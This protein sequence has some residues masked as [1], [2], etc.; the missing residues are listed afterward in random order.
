MTYTL[1][2]SEVSYFTG[3]A[4]AFLDWKRID[5]SEAPAT[6]D[7]YRD[8]IMPRVGWPVIPVVLGPGEEVLQDTSDII[9]ILDARHGPPSVFPDGPVQKLAALL[10]E[11]YGDE[12]LVLPAMH[13]RWSYNRDFAYSEFGKLSA[14]EAPAE[15]QYEIGRA[16]AK[17]FE[18]AL[19]VLGIDARTASAIESGYCEMLDQLD[20]HFARH[21]MLLG[22][23]PSIGDF[24]LFG[25]LYAHQYRDPES[26]KLMRERAP[27]LVRWVE[28][29]RN[30][31]GA[32]PGEFLPGDEV[33]ETLL[34]VFETQMEDQFP[35][36]ANTAR[37]LAAWAEG[38]P[39][40]T[41]VPRAL[42]KHEFRTHGARG[43][44]MIFPF[45][46]W[47][48]QRPIEHYR[49]LD[50]DARA[51]ADA[52]LARVGG[53]VFRDFPQF[54]ALRRQDYRLVLA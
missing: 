20:A 27:N 21:E 41:Q 34:P 11:L 38:Q 5:Y 42:G 47:M 19:P 18:G 40:G 50:A 6:R 49:S 51:R 36:L 7:I 45:N 52:F 43:E 4:R 46:L 44:R 53:D 8:V 54:P 28:T 37:A 23:R 17:N 16:N 10:L 2:G 24:G 15:E 31:G 3:K 14:P 32:Y 33:P 1:Y 35:C 9:D 48:L 26:G 12:W 22:S 30:N 13:Y 39:A 29:L 25:P